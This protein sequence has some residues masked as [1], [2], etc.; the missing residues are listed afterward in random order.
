[1]AND[2]R[3]TVKNPNGTYRVPIERI[4]DGIRIEVSGHNIGVFGELVNKLG[5]LEDKEELETSKKDIS[6]VEN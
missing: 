6:N 3:M 2:I 5:R 1:M 4:G